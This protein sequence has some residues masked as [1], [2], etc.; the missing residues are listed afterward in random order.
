ML[1]VGCDFIV[2]SS[3]RCAAE[4]TIA[5]FSAV[6]GRG[7]GSVLIGGPST[8]DR[9]AGA[10]LVVGCDHRGVR[11][12]SRWAGSRTPAR[13]P[14]LA[15]PSAAPSQVVDSAA[16]EGARK[17]NNDA[18]ITSSPPCRLHLACGLF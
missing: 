10:R 6:S 1:T 9:F 18:R 12:R 7:F 5:F 8:D 3:L 16:V 17:T 14:F 13:G 15:T 2:A 11:A 4:A